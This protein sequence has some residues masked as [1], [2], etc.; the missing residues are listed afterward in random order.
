MRSARFCPAL[1]GPLASLRALTGVLPFLSDGSEP[2]DDVFLAKLRLALQLAR[3]SW[4]ALESDGVLRQEVRTVLQRI[5]EEQHP[6]LDHFSTLEPSRPLHEY[7]LR[8]VADE[9]AQSIHVAFHYIGYY[10]HGLHLGLFPSSQQ[11][12]GWPLTLL[13]FSE[14]DMV[15]ARRL[16][17]ADV[18]A[19]EVAVL[20]RVYASP[21][22]PPNAFS[23][24]FR[25]SVPLLREQHPRLQLI[26]T[27]LNP[28]VGFTGASYRASNWNFLAADSHLTYPYLDDQYVTTRE[29]IRR[30]G[31]GEK[32]E[33]MRNLGGRL[34]WSQLPLEP[35]Q[36]FSYRLQRGRR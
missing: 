31:T 27:Y 5:R 2:G 24:S 1:E 29:L 18:E 25:R 16:L 22:A 17:P 20:S 12:S 21:K 33:L 32:T 36:L 3:F 6:H 35:L 13:T 26:M 7:E 23:Y 34:T 8:P 19:S 28:N 10:H 15:S 9:I 14:L 4:Q 11:S 30:F